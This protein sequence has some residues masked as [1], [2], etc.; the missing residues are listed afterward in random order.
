MDKTPAPNNIERTVRD[1]DSQGL[2]GYWFTGCKSEA[3]KEQVRTILLNS[4]IQF[5][6]LK[7]ILENMFREHTFK[8]GDLD[9]PNLDQRL[10]YNE[11]YINALQDIYRLLP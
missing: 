7:R 3:E 8:H 6:L 1:K 9:K 5:R 4:N 10:M 11:G 2:S